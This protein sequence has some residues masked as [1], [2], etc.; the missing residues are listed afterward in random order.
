MEQMRRNKASDSLI[1]YKSRIASS[2]LYIHFSACVIAA[3]IFYETFILAF[4]LELSGKVD[5]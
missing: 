5:F 4:L 2:E 1:S 3:V